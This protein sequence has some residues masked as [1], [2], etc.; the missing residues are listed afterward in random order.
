MVA[1]KVS[2]SSNTSA[3]DF[4]A[5]FG[6]PKNYIINEAA[7]EAAFFELNKTHHPDNARDESQ[8]AKLTHN[9]ALINEGHRTLLNPLTRALYM[10]KIAG[11]NTQSIPQ[12][13]AVL[14]QSMEDREALMDADSAT[15]MAQLH[16]K[17]HARLH[18]LHAHIAAAFDAQKLEAAAALTTELQY[19]SKF[20][21][22]IEQKQRKN[23]HAA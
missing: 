6:L 2:M 22:E 13:E 9:S 7:L 20:L 15:Q 17:T 19:V 10:L 5:L 4:F 21:S 12:S 23:T 16:T 3:Q 8:R 11:V 1:A 14:M 18:Q